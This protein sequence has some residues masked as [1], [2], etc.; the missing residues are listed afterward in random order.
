V[1]HDDVVT[2]VKMAWNGM[3][4]GTPESKKALLRKL[5]WTSQALQSARG[6][7]IVKLDAKLDGSRLDATVGAP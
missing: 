5:S 4:T 6:K 7:K 2:E 3:G 1:S